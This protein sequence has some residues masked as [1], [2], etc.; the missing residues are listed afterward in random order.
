MPSSMLLMTVSSCSRSCRTS[1][2]SP[3][4]VSA[5]ALNSWPSQARVSEPLTGTRRWRSPA[6]I[7]RA[8]ALEALEPA[9]HRDADDAGDG[10]HEKQGQADAAGGHPA[11]V[12]V[13]G[14]ADLARI[15]VDDEDAVDPV[16]RIVAP[17]AGLAVAHRDHGAQE[18]RISRL[19]DPAR[20][21]LLG[22]VAVAGLTGR[23]AQAQ[24]GVRPRRRARVPQLPLPVEQHH[25]LDLR[26]VPEGLDHALDQAA[27]VLQH[28]VLETR[29]DQL[30]LRQ[31]RRPRSRQQGLEVV[32]RVEVGADRAGDRDRRRDADGKS[33]GHARQA[34]PHAVPRTHSKQRRLGDG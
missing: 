5:M 28:L 3:V 13:H 7:R 11:E 32:D 6:A 21:P 18:R 19:D 9:H 24:V 30:S 14:G 12:P 22:G 25:P 33:P 15:E 23:R 16:L 34:E 17:E 4:I 27:V 10:G 1:L 26:L 20:G 29:P 8:V 31:R 2:S